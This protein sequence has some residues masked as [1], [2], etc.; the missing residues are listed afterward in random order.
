ME[1]ELLSLG[2]AVIEHEYFDALLLEMGIRVTRPSV[3]KEDNQAAI[4]YTKGGKT[5]TKARHI[6]VKFHYI[7][8]TASAMGR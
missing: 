2:D 7:S 6:G 3:I 1:A 5:E 8:G 4:A